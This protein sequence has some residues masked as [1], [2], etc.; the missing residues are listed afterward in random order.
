MAF[1]WAHSSRPSFPVLVVRHH[2]FGF[3]LIP[4][5]SDGTV[6]KEPL[7]PTSAVA[8]VTAARPS[9]SSQFV[10][11]EHDVSRRARN[12]GLRTWA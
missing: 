12:A 4:H 11:S 10:C 9:R 2:T 5:A 1:M 3:P 8:V 7:E 6:R